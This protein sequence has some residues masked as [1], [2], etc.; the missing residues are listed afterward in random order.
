[1]THTFESHQLAMKKYKWCLGIHGGICSQISILISTIVDN[2]IHII[3]PFKPPEGDRSS[4]GHS[5][6]C[7]GN[8][9]G[10]Y[11]QKSWLPFLCIF[12]FKEF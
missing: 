5:E 2:E 3:C 10:Q 4:K 7:K 8:M 9:N 1:M 6:A 11:W 12:P